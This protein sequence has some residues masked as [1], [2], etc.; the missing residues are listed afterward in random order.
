MGEYV[1]TP[2]QAMNELP[3]MGGVFNVVNLH[4][5]HYAGNNPVKYTDPDGREDT[6]GGLWNAINFDFGAD[7]ANF[8]YQNI[9]DGD[10]GW[11]L[12]NSLN[13]LSEATYDLLGLYAVAHGIGLL[14]TGVTKATVGLSSAAINTAL[15]SEPRIHHAADHLIKARILPNWSRNTME[16]A[17]QLYTNILS[18]LSKVFDHVL[19]GGQEVKGYLSQISGKNVVVFIYKTGDF[20]GQIA[21]S[22]VPT[23]S[24]MANWG[25]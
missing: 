15:Q 21:T 14:A 7:Y 25:L 10:Y 8:A 20:A 12:I 19:K 5:Y 18:N 9:K 3:G 24:E 13:A 23:A 22:F 16:L 6:R 4:V 2:G 11:A 1:P 17:K